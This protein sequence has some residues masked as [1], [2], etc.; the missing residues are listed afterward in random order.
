MLVVKISINLSRIFVLMCVAESDHTY[1]QK[2]IG[3]QYIASVATYSL[4]LSSLVD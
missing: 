1:H 2:K 3:W 4:S